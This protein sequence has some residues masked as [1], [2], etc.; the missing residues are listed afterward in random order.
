MLLSSKMLPFI[1][2]LYLIGSP[3]VSVELCPG[4]TLTNNMSLEEKAGQVLMV[5]FHGKFANEEAKTLIQD[6]KV[7]GIIY[8]NWANGLNSPQ[9]V[10]ELSSGLQKLVLVNRIPIPLLI[11]T[12]QEGGVVSRLTDGFTIFPGNGALGVTGDVQLA[13]KAA[14]AMGLELRAVGINMNLAPV[15][16]VNSNSRNPVIGIRSFG[17][18]PETVIAFGEK[19]LC[20]YNE[21]QIIATLKHFPGYGDVAVDPHEDLP[22]IHKSIEDLQR[23]ELLPFEKLASSADAIMT[24]HLLVPSLDAENCSTL[25]EKTLTYLKEVIGFKG[26]IVADSLIMGG[27]LKKCHTVDEAVIRALSAGCDLLILGGKFLNGEHVGFE[28]TVADVQRIHQSIV[29]AVKTG[30]I[31]EARLNQAVEKIVKLKMKYLGSQVSDI[32]RMPLYEV[33]NTLDHRAIAQQVAALAVRTV[34]GEISSIGSLQQKKVLVVAPQ[35]LSDA[36]KQ[37]PLLK[38]GKT[39]EILFFNGLD[40]SGDEVEAAKRSAKT[41][42][43]LLFCSYNAWKNPAQTALIHSLIDM[44]KPLVVLNSRDPLDAAE[45]PKA[46]LV[47]NSFSPTAPSIQAVCNQLCDF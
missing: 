19:A 28:L 10:Q 12:D 21:A 35:I 9:Q 30:R 44:G 40:P 29:T 41:A 46:S 37:T 22:V 24:A 39:T 13:E 32:Q 2:I 27:V 5:H 3:C 18:T 36:I 15:V 23:G 16:D 26:V 17:A 14:C 47:F 6:T 7:G 8:Y 1:G 4:S 38:I 33:V 34:Q 43:V 42:D 11:A 25:S 20:G 31:S 45:F